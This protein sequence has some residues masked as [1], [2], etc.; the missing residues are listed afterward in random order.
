MISSALARRIGRGLSSMNIVL[1]FTEA[2][3]PAPR[4]SYRL[5]HIGVGHHDLIHRHLP[6]A[7][8]RERDVLRRLRK[9]DQLAG[10]LLR[11]QALGTT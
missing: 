6:I 1:V 8:R 9:A 10:V 5:T 3:G 2:P 4:E 11:E 7:H